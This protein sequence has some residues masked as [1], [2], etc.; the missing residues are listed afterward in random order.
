MLRKGY[1]AKKLTEVLESIA[2]HEGD[3]RKRVKIAFMYLNHLK[4]TDFPDDLKAGWNWIWKEST[5]YGPLH[6]HHGNV[7][8]GSI[9]NT[10]RRVKNSTASKILKKIYSLYWGVTQN[11]AYF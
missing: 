5:K 11:R 4:E 1:A 8:R 10:M 2:T 3:A 6:D 9:E 7:R